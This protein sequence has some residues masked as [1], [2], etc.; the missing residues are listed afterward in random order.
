MKFLIYL[1]VG[2]HTKVMRNMITANQIGLSKLFQEYQSKS[3]KTV[4]AGTKYI[5]T[6]IEEKGWLKEAQFSLILKLS[7][8]ISSALISYDGKEFLV[9][10][11]KQFDLSECDYS[12]LQPIT[13]NAGL[14][15]AILAETPLT[16]DKNFRELDF[17]ENIASQHLNSQFK[18]Y[19]FED[20]L[21]F[22]PPIFAFEIPSGSPF[23][24]VDVYRV[25]CYLLLMD[26]VAISLPFEDLTTETVLKLVLEEEGVLTFEN[27][28]YA[29]S[30]ANWR[31][32][33]LEF[34]RCIERLYPIKFLS[35][36]YNEL[37]VSVGFLDFAS[38]IES[39]TGWKPKED[40]AIETLLE[41]ITQD[42]SDMYSEFLKTTTENPNVLIHRYLYKLRNAIVHFR[43][44]HQNVTLSD[45]Q[46]NHLIRLNSD[47]IRHFYKYY[48]I[49]LIR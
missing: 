25:G 7:S 39:V 44:I 3:G 37:S 36:L 15:T 29:L 27:I 12:A 18:G 23:K 22:L 4:R 48:K 33:Y 16:L 32:S 30:S 17:E 49:Q 20:L 34:Y 14:L 31:H 1:L 6:N 10:Y 13:M 38:K 11:G 43:A 41:D 5:S 46:W 40:D 2:A 19:N 8:D 42:I 47:I 35:N 45:I 24:H 9:V 21:P 28:F 26:K